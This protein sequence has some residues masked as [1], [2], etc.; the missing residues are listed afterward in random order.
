[1]KF[2]DFHTHLDSY[3]DRASLETQLA[4]FDGIIVAASMS[5]SSYKENLLIAGRAEASSF[6]ARVVPTLGAHPARAEEEI[7]NLSAYKEA[8]RSASLIG[9][10]GMDF[11]WHKDI[12][13]ETQEKVFRF[14]LEHCEETGKYCVIHTKD[15]EERICRIL[16]DYPNAK[17]IIH[18]YDGPD[19]VYGEF[20]RR[21]YMQTFGCQT[22]R[23]KHLQELL[24]RTP[25]DRIL[26][27]T[28]NPD[29]EV[30]LGGSDSSVSLIKRI[31]GDIANVLGIE[32]EKAADIINANSL[33]ILRESGVELE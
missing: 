33:R 28:D 30:W 1:M 21:G 13:L 14:F 8:L 5:L 20:M 22:M 17:P 27:E 7:G 25:H 18:W 9:E 15:A 19:D 11:C 29:S 12:P 23:S 16:E 26:A 2:V 32:M 31:Y 6:K 4:G 24:R 10:I 3:K